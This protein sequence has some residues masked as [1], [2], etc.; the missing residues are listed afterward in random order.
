MNIVTEGQNLGNDIQE[1]EPA[2]RVAL[3]RVGVTGIKRV[4]RLRAPGKR[5][6]TLFFAEMDMFAH[7]DSSRSG[8]H[9]SRFIENIEGISSSLAAESSPDIET[10]AER[11]AL[12]IATA[13]GTKRAE[14]RIRAQFP[15]THPA[16]V[17]GMSVED[18]YTFIGI[19]ISDGLAARRAIGVE[20]NGLTVCPCAREMAAESARESLISAGYSAE[21]AA[22]IIS[23]V[24][25]ASHNQRGKGTLVI[26]TQTSLRAET[27]VAVAEDAMSSGIYELMKRPDELHVVLKAHSRP[28]FVEDVVREMI[29]GVAG[30]IPELPDD[31]FVM[32]RQENFESIHTHNA[33]AERCG[34]LG[35]MRRELSGGASPPRGY[36]SLEAWLDSLL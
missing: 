13:Q 12:A 17:S 7:L 16:P 20:V 32:A 35:E 6:N 4:L 33:S 25:I 2:T 30:R 18:L 26:G 31:A 34:L 9:M 8:V 15:M 14:V 21:Q 24:P 3:S 19:A 29:G 22:E 28:R 23:I 36:A 5:G 10:L 27:L 1:S 11:M